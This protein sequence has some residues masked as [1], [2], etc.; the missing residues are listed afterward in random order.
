MSL[1][2]LP[3]LF[4]LAVFSFLSAL[5]VLWVIGLRLN[6]KVSTHIPDGL[7]TR[8]DEI[9]FL[10][11]GNR[12]IDASRSA[13]EFLTADLPA[14]QELPEIARLLAPRFPDLAA[15]LENLPDAK[16][17]HI[18]TPDGLGRIGLSWRDGDVRLV[19]DDRPPVTALTPAPDTV[20]AAAE[21]ELANLRAVAQTAPFLVWRQNDEGKIIWANN[22]Y[23][24]LARE[25]DSTGTASVW[26]PNKVFADPE[27]LPFP[28]EMDTGRISLDLPGASEPRW[29]ERHVQRVD[30]DVLF[31]AVSADKTVL[32]ERALRDFVQTLTKTFA[33]LTIGLAIFDKQRRLALFNPAMAD[34]TQ[35]KPDFLSMRPSLLAFLDRL[36]DKRMIPEPRDYKSWRQQI[37]ELESAANDGTYEETWPLPNGQTF[38][39]TGRPHPDGA[40]AFLFEDISAEVSL[41]RRFRAEMET[42]QAVLD[43]LDEA[44]AVFSPSGL[45]TL[46]NAAYARLWGDDPSTKV[47]G[48]D[49]TDAS[50]I[51]AAA[52]APTPVWGDFREF[53]GAFG[54]RAEWSADL[55]LKDGRALRCH[56][57]PLTGGAT[58]VTFRAYAA[59]QKLVAPQTSAEALRPENQ[60]IDGTVNG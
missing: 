10:F 15:A 6:R 60:V 38:R 50:K 17:D 31:T 32:A 55:R 44:I 7:P 3:Q 14:G 47:D 52:C 13:Q 1:A 46:S 59:D 43:S 35:L 21:E 9:I 45:L 27:Q 30:G 58:L 57:G 48:P 29:Y 36:R 33:H 8:G 19:L 20:S 41:T 5:A 40:L 26:P 11:A 39:V 56:F 22:A 24:D 51:W 12:L 37:Q 23:L 42:G 16:V 34:L 28:G 4:A 2:L 54:E 53:V 18:E 49:V 25:C